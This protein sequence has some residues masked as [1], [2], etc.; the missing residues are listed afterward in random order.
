LLTNLLN[1]IL[2]NTR[3]DT[4]QRILNPTNKKNILMRRPLRHQP[5]M[6]NLGASYP[7]PAS[8]LEP[9]KALKFIGIFV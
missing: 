6:G 5:I 8:L 4:R 7:S 2:R 9:I 1:Y 3:V